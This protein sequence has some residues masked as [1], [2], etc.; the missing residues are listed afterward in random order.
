MNNPTVEDIEGEVIPL[1]HDENTDMYIAFYKQKGWD[2]WSTSSLRKSKEE[3]V[4]SLTW[5]E[6]VVYIKVMKVR[7]PVNNFRRDVGLVNE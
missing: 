7:L 2:W 3:A 6:D 1:S 5:N 4:S